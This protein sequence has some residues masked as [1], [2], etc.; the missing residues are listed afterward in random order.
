MAEM[1]PQLSLDEVKKMR[2]KPAAIEEARKAGQL[3]ELLAGRN[4]GN[5]PTCGRP[6]QSEEQK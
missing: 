2:R 4:P 6:N 1:L 3:D 5:C